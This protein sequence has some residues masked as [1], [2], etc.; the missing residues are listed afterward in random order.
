MLNS[1][2]DALFV[3]CPL[4]VLPDPEAVLDVLVDLLAEPTCRVVLI[5]EEHEAL[6]CVVDE[7]VAAAF[8]QDPS[9]LPMTNIYAMSENMTLE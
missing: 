8:A 3:H 5:A 1:L 7:P 6:G 2:V 9:A 4:C